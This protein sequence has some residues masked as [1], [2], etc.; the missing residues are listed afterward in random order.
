[1]DATST[2]KKDQKRKKDQ[3]E[4]EPEREPAYLADR[5]RPHVEISTEFT[6]GRNP[7]PDALPTESP[8]RS[9][10]ALEKDGDLHPEPIATLS[11]YCVMQL[12]EKTPAT[13]EEFDEQKDL[14]VRQLRIAKEADALTAY[15][16]RLREK[17]A[18]RISQD[19]SLV[20]DGSTDEA[21]S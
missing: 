9:A 17:Y 10:F 19:L 14:I 7:V 20:D 11:G 15:I 4:A 12:K 13:R 1:V 3:D 8:A 2:K 21:D 5:R 16:A 6:I 18:E